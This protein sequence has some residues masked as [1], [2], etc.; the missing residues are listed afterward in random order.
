MDRYISV[1]KEMRVTSNLIAH[2][3]FIVGESN[4]DGSGFL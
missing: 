4:D 2:T 3:E 1:H